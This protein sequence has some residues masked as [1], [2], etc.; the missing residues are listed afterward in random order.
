MLLY[1]FLCIS[2]APQLCHTLLHAAPVHMLFYILVRTHTHTK[3]MRASVGK[4]WFVKNSHMANSTFLNFENFFNKA[5]LDI[6]YS[7]VLRWEVSITV[8]NNMLVM[9][10]YKSEKTRIIII[11]I[12]YFYNLNTKF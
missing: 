7:S 11:I 9:K 8:Y 3:A 4:L 1:N 2:Q 6:E 12:M 5:I 10:S